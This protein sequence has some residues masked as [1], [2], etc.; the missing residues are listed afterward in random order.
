MRRRVYSRGTGG[1]TVSIRVTEEMLGFI[2]Q[3]AN[4]EGETRNAYIVLAL[5]SVLQMKAEAGLIPWPKGYDP[6]NQKKK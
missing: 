6:K 2:E 1:V 3:L 4:E 5:D